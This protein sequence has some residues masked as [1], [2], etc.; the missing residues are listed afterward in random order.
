[1]RQTRQEYIIENMVQSTYYRLKKGVVMSIKLSF[2][3]LGHLERVE[4]KAPF[5][6][7]KRDLLYTRI[8]IHLLQL[9]SA[10]SKLPKRLEAA[11]EI[12]HEERRFRRSYVYRL[13]AH[14]V[15]SERAPVIGVCLCYK[16]SLKVCGPAC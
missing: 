12:K 8:H 2:A 15:S 13:G 11:V 9:F 10:L 16:A 7:T 3:C 5:H 4:P 1:M 14:L 6:E